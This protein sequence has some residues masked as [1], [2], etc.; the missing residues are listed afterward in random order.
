[1]SGVDQSWGARLQ[2]AVYTED[3]LAAHG[4]A[5]A[6]ITTG[7]LV[8]TAF[9]LGALAR[10]AY[11]RTRDHRA[12]IRRR[13]RALQN[14]S[15]PSQG[16]LPPTARERSTI[17]VPPGYRLL[18]DHDSQKAAFTAALIE[19]QSSLCVR[20]LDGRWTVLSIEPNPEGAS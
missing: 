12:Q 15:V 2:R 8:I 17:Y 19:A 11:V 14:A 5:A 13:A 1:M 9:V 10:L 7:A 20:K 4:T 16:P 6:Y 18:S 3:F